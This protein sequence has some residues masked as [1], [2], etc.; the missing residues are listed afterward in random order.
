M[1]NR[2]HFVH[3]KA[4]DARLREVVLKALPVAVGGIAD[5]L[6]HADLENQMD[7]ALEVEPQLDVIGNC[8]LQRL[9]SHPV[10]DA[11]KAVAEHNQ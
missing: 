3:R 2:V 1:G 6:V 9:R 7:S 10:R 4:G 8:L 5:R 11:D